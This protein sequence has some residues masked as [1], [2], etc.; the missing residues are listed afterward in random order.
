M[1]S[2]V[3]KTY[4]GPE[5]LELTELSTPVPKPNEV[6]IQIKSASINPADW[7]IL[8]ADP[9]LIRAGH[10]LLKP[11]FSHLGSDVSGIVVSLGTSATKWKVGDEV[12]SDIMGSG[13]GAYG[14][15]VAVPE[16]IL[17]RKPSN[18][19]FDEAAAVPIA[20]LTAYQGLLKYGKLEKGQN[21]LINGA[22]GGVGTYAVQI[23]KHIGANVTAICSAK[24]EE[25]VLALGADKV[26]AYDKED[27]R[28]TTTQFDLIM[29]NV[30]NCSVKDA[31]SMLKPKGIALLVGWGGFGHM[32]RFMSQGAIASKTS[33][34]TF[35]GIAAKLDT[36]DLEALMELLSSQAIRSVID[37]SFPMDDLTKAIIL[38]EKGRTK[39]KIVVHN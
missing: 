25:F 2:Y 24:N 5:V 23:A 28:I 13:M 1:K 7:R 19:S 38:Q 35:M 15:Y 21:V 34:R 30:G 4:G 37:K 9:F 3:R 14:E 22:S 29:D 12:V 26:I 17:V 27:Y 36:A 20:G 31:K 33:G 8:R 18:V 11:K 6:L 16:D 10:G 32:L 39:G